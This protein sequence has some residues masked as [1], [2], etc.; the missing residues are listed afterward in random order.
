MYKTSRE[1]LD[2]KIKTFSKFGDTGHGG[3]TR[4]SLSAEAISARDE[5]CKRCLALGMGIVTDD[6]ANI[7]ATIPGEEN[8]PAIMT[9]SHCDSVKNGV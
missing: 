6:M 2:E 5:F 3:I 1:R 8:L 7:Y 9:G 4:F